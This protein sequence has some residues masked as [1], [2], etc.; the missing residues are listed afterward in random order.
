VKT[1]KFV[2]ADG[3]YFPGRIEFDIHRHRR[4]RGIVPSRCSK[5]RISFLERR[6]VKFVDIDSDT[7]S[8]FKLGC[9]TDVI[10]VTVSEN[11]LGELRTIKAQS[12]NIDLDLMYAPSRSRVDQDK[13]S[14]VQEIDTAVSAVCDFG[15]SDHE[16]SLGHF[17]RFHQVFSCKSV[18][19]S[20]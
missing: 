11:E 5:D 14:Q 13:F 2:I 9:T 16:N 12:F 7:Q 8:F 6:C 10:D 1:D 15:P 4:K 19:I 18:L 20:L 3:E 17:K